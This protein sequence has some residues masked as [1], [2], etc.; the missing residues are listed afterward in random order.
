MVWI[1]TVEKKSAEERLEDL[2]GGEEE[3]RRVGR[4][5]SKEVRMEVGGFVRECGRCKIIGAV[6]GGRVTRQKG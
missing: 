2:V 5:W 3:S 6:A 1:K 4:W